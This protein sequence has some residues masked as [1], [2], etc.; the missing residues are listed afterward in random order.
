[1]RVEPLRWACLLA[2]AVIVAGTVAVSGIVGWV[3][4]VVPHLARMIVGPDHRRLIPASFLL[5]AA[6]LTLM[7]DL[8]R[9][10]TPAEIPIGIITA[11]VGAPVF[12]VLMRRAKGTGWTGE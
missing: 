9:G 4:L 1:M 3:G 12:L 8:A 7:D 10:L 2:T 11:L 5:G 6:F